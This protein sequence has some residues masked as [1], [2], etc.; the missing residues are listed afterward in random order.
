MTKRHALMCLLSA[1]GHLT[2]GEARRGT[3]RLR[4]CSAHSYHAGDYQQ[5]LTKHVNGYRC[6]ANTGV[7]FPSDS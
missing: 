1:R 4:G 3:V 5:Y 7:P 2:C 6:H